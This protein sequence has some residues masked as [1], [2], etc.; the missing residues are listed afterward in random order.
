MIPNMLQ[1]HEFEKL[2][3]TATTNVFSP[4]NKY[5]GNKILLLKY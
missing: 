5:S 4:W 3:S 1:L 2:L